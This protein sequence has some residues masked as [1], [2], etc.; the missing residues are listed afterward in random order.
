MTKLLGIE[1]CTTICSVALWDGKHVHEKINRSPRSHSKSL[2]P[3]IAALLAEQ[4]LS[5]S[6]IDALACARGPGSFTGVRIGV[7]VVKGLA[8]GQDLPI[9]P[10]SPLAAI[11]YR[12]IQQTQ[13]SRVTALLDARMGELYAADYENK[14]GLPLLIGNERLTDI[15]HLTFSGQ[16]VAGTGA[17]EY[18]DILSTKAVSIAA[19]VYPYAADIVGLARH[20]MQTAVSATDFTPLYLRDKVTD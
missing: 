8:F 11:A 13:A 19:A 20:A 12:V 9:I 14:A 18:A 6:D 16:T 5:I 2:L 4:Q 10:V 3:M 15:A 1:T 17:E 7:G